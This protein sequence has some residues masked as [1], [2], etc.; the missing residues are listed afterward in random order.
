MVAYSRSRVA[1]ESLAGGYSKL[2]VVGLGEYF[3]EDGALD[4]ELAFVTPDREIGK[5]K[6][7]GVFGF[8]RGE[9]K[10]GIE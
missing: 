10:R 4:V 3:G 7:E 1:G 5:T 9:E 2:V 8:L 6:N